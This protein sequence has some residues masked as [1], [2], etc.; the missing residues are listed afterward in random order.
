LLAARWFAGSLL[1]VGLWVGPL[2]PPASPFIPK[3]DRIAKAATEVNKAASRT[4]ALML[5]LTLRVADRDP[6]G[7]GKLL[8]HPNGLARLELRDAAQR[9]ERHL[10]LGAEHSASRGGKEIEKPRAFLPP[11]FLLQADSP[12]TLQQALSDYGLDTEAV[13]L[14]PCGSQVCYVLG[15]PARVASPPRPRD[16]DLVELLA[17]GQ[18]LEQLK[19][20]LAAEQTPAPR[21]EDSGDLGPGPPSIWIDSET[22][23]IVRMQSQSGVIVEFG[24]IRSFEAVRFPESITI[25]ES[26]REP[27]HLDVKSVTPVNAAA[28][29]FQRAWLLAPPES[30]NP[31]APAALP[32]SSP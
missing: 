25:Q 24:R 17:D 20:A 13:A 3:A 12:L 8:T 32:G 9:L 6:I 16:E 4:Q 5:E 27:V 26:D 14:A 2:A 18:S 31:S 30:G 1:V 22:F 23:E 7:T 11:L 19:Q 29:G 21:R 15:D 10:L 28:A